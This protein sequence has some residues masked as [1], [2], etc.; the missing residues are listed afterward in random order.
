M[1]KMTE[2]L[3]RR[4]ARRFRTYD[5]DRNGFLERGDFEASAAR[6]AEEFGHGPESP[7]RQKLVALGLGLW[8]HLVKVADKDADGRIGLAEYKA[9]F[10][11]GLLETP[12][13]FEQG[14]VPFLDAIMEIV[15]QDHDGKLTV[16]DEIRWTKAMMHLPEHDARE[17]FRRID[18]DG[19]GFITVSD[20][21][22]AIRGYYFDESP[23]SPG[24]WLLGPLDS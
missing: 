16:T 6:M 23:D 11:A 22:E 3:E 9:A 5:D 15:D 12:E 19:D 20:L 21:L 18:K 7:A 2:F 24:H 13:S 4:L 1:T 17:T 14:Y 8:E 10:A